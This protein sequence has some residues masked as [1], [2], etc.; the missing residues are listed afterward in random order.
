MKEEK[1]FSRK[2][3]VITGGSSGIG[4]SLAHR[5]ARNGASVMILARDPEK[6]Q[7]AVAE[8]RLSA[9]R[10]DQAIE[11]FPVDVTDAVRVREVMAEI[12]AR[13]QSIDV[14][15]NS[16]GMSQSGYVTDLK[17]EDYHRL[18]DV[19]FFGTLH[20][21]QAALPYMVRQRSGHIA[22]I[23]SVL[24]LFA[25]FGFSTY[26][27]SKY[28]TAGLTEVLRAELKPRGIRVSLV[29]AGYADTPMYT[30]TRHLE[31][32]E[33]YAITRGSGIIHPDQV[34]EV[35]ARK[36]A[37]GDY[38]IYANFEARILPFL[39]RLW[40]GLANRIL[41]FMASRAKPAPPPEK[42]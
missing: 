35:A 14:L 17:L 18:M 38:M 12:A 42:E 33:T 28:A 10:G 21:I 13:R 41:D 4:K 9:R 20:T 23:G 39:S 6:L 3:A 8:I 26:A 2:V 27:S 37:E 24:S 5:L 36:M 30:Q 34:A 32:P 15:V 11:C 29:I 19:N 1:Y 25:T 31:P 40:P 22:N 7:A 16:A